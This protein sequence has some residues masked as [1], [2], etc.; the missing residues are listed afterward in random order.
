MLGWESEKSSDEY[1]TVWMR[2]TSAGG[3]RVLAQFQFSPLRRPC[4]LEA[5]TG[6]R[7][8]LPAV[9][10]FPIMARHEQG[11]TSFF[12]DNGYRR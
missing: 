5:A 3:P 11:K 8:P 12:H 6:P 2:P 4:A 10:R 1:M 7:S 9:Q